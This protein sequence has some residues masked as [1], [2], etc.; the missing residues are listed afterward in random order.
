MLAHCQITDELREKV[1]EQL[2]YETTQMTAAEAMQVKNS[3]RHLIYRHRYYATS[4]W[5][6]S[7]QYISQYEKLLNEIH[8]NVP[9]YEYSYLFRRR[10]DY[11][12]LHPTPYDKEEGISSNENATEEL[13]Q[14]S[15][16]EFNEK[17][18]KISALAE[19]CANESNCTLGSYLA[20]Y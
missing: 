9:E 15:L 17:G 11:P 16:I 19:V 8:L 7:E 14:E 12:L 10:G 6:M 13:I 5:A 1:F 18:Y 4:S 20:K 3:I 2:L